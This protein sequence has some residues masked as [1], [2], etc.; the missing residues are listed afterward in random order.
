VWRARIAVRIPAISIAL[1]RL[2]LFSAVRLITGTGIVA[3]TP[4]IVAIRA[5]VA[6]LV[7]V[8]AIAERVRAA[9]L[10]QRRWGR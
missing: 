4:L 5:A 1:E 6:R 2:D 10:M 8:S 7:A 9:V 3:R